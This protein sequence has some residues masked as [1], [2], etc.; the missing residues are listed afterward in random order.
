[1]K[2]LAMFMEEKRYKVVMPVFPLRWLYVCGLAIV[3]QKMII[4]NQTLCGTLICAQGLD[5]ADAWAIIAPVNWYSCTSNLKLMFDRLV[6]MNGGN[7]DEKTIDHKNPKRQ[8]H[9][10]IQSNGK[11]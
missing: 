11:K 2:I 3:M 6:C 9:S 1:M 8:W 7:P 4:K 5:M 10:K